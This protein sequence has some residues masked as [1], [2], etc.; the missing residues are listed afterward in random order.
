[1]ELE[2]FVILKLN[3]KL[4]SPVLPKELEREVTRHIGSE[5]RA[6]TRD[7]IRGLNTLQERVF[8]PDL[9]GVGPD[10]IDFNKK[11][12]DFWADFTIEPTVEGVKLNI[13]TE[14]KTVKN[15]EGE[16]VEVDTPVVL[17]DYM[18]YQFAKQSSKVA[19]TRDDIES[20]TFMFVLLDLAEEQRLKRVAFDSKKSAMV[21]FAR[22][23][24][25][26]TP[27]SKL[28]WVIRTLKGID[29]Y[30]DFSI[31]RAEKEMYLES[32]LAEN[33][34]LFNQKYE[35]PDLETKALLFEAIEMRQI[36]IEGN[37]YFLQDENLGTEKSAIDYLTAPANSAKVL[38][39]K[40]RLNNIGELQK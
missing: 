38:A 26:K 10:S 1:M 5:F 21:N 3:D 17:E 18:V 6:G 35:D 4:K 28:D 32:K 16:S 25:E 20:E 29:E 8:L 34:V 2:K 7:C 31:T 23:T 14:K 27:E 22:L 37:Y 39:L 19:K 30:F 36:T 9:I 15:R 24:S 40:A 11:V 12:R 13:A 33:P